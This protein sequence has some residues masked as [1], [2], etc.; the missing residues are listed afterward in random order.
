VKAT[1]SQFKSN[2]TDLPFIR[3]VSET[4]NGSIVVIHGFGGCKEEQLGLS[5][6]L[7]EFG[8]DTYA[9]DLRG[10]G[11]NCQPLSMDVLDDVNNFVRS[12]KGAGRTIA[13]GHSL[14][15]RLSLLCEADIR[16]GISPALSQT[17]SEQTISI[18][19]QMRQHRVVENQPDANFR[20]LS[21]LPLVDNSMGSDDLILY[22]GRDIPEIVQACEA[23][24]A[25]GKNV[26]RFDKALHGDT[27]LL[28]A[29][30]QHLRQWLLQPGRL[31]SC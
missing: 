9:I 1:I 19:N 11:Q 24:A 2:G 10:H 16:I 4:R 7:A 14:G 20:I 21:A 5:F 12:L 8:F 22:G 26:V 3:F 17:F 27:F 6:R 28:E 25:K 15:G 13:I 18:V 30:F 23:L 29:S 31:M